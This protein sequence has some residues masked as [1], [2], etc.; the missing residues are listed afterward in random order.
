[1]NTLSKANFKGKKVLVR[2]DLNS[3]II[4]NKVIENQRFK[5]H[6][7]TIKELKKKKAKIVLL[8]HQ[9]RPKQKDFTDLKQHAKILS[10]YV[11]VKFVPIVGKESRSII[12]NLKEGEVI[13]LDNVRKLKDEYEGSKNN[14]F[15][16]VLSK[17]FDYYVNDAF[18]NSHRKHASMV[19]FPKVLK[20]F[21]GR[22]L[23]EEVKALKKLHVGKAL[24]ILGGAKPKDNIKLLN[25]KRKILSCGLFGQLSLIAKGVN[26]GAQNKFLKNKIGIV[27]KSKLKN[28]QFP[29]D[30]AIKIGN[31]RKELQLNEFPSKYEIFDIGGRTIELYKEEIKKAKIIFMK[32][33]PGDFLNENFS[34]GTREILKAIGKNKGFSVVGG[35]SSS[36]AVSKFKIKGINHISLSGGALIEFVSG[37][38]LVG[39]EVLK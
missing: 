6:S 15:V 21:M 5:A 9:G 2:I 10:K 1:M 35:G 4:N 31:K 16:K 11:K 8:A 28:V 33:V 25:N 3:E 24:F 12:D 27:K 29:M 22:N 30:F 39:L 34:K 32:G 26:F 23:E 20:S 7:K 36:D 19:G 37:K 13:L 38:K 17:H 14:K 18:S